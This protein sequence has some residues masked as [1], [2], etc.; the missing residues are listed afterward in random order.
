MLGNK[1]PYLH[2]KVN[3]RHIAWLADTGAMVSIASADQFPPHERHGLVRVPL[4]PGLKVQGATGH[5]FSLAGMFRLQLETNVGTFPHNVLLVEGLHTGKFI[6]GVDFLHKYGA[7]IDCADHKITFPYNSMAKIDEVAKGCVTRTD[8]QAQQGDIT[9]QLCQEVHLQ[10]GGEKQIWARAT[11]GNRSDVHPN[12]PFI[13]SGEFTVDALV[14]ADNDSK[15]PVILHNRS[16]HPITL[17]RGTTVATGDEVEDIMQVDEVL[18]GKGQENPRPTPLSPEKWAYLRRVIKHG[19]HGRT[20]Q[21]FW[22]LVKEHHEAFSANAFDL[23]RTNAI[24][25]KILMRNKE[26]V[27][28]KQF[29]LNWSSMKTIDDHVDEL[30]KKDCIEPSLSRF[31][32]PIFVVPKKDHSGEKHFRVVQDLREVN[33]NSLDDKYVGRD[34]GDCLGAIGRAKSTIFSKLD[35]TSGFWQM[36]LHPDSREMTAFTIPGR[37][38]FHWTVTTMG[39]KGSPASFA[40]LMD[41]VMANVKGVICYQ[42]DCLVHGQ[43]AQQHMAALRNAFIRLKKFSLKLNA[44]KC[45]FA[46]EKV[47]Y[48]G[49]TLTKDGI[50]PGIDKLKAVREF[51]AP[52]NVKAVRSF[53]GLTNYFRHMVPDYAFLSTHLSHLLTKEANWTGGPL[54]PRATHAFNELRKRLCEAP[55]LAFPRTDRPFSV[56]VDAATGDQNN[57]GGIGAVLTQRDA[58][59]VEHVIAYG[60]RAL[61]KHEKN[62]S[63]YLLEALAA[64]YF[65]DHW[66]VFLK[67]V[68]FT[69]FT[70]HKPLEAL[71]HLHK[72]TLNRLQQQQSEF[73]FT[74]RHRPGKTNTVADALSRYPVRSSKQ[75]VATIQALG[76]TTN[77]IRKLQSE[78]TFCRD[79]H[80]FRQD[81]T[82]PANSKDRSF[83]DR[84]NPQISQESDGLLYYNVL[85]AAG[86]DSK[87]MVLPRVLV[88]PIYQFAHCSTLAGHGGQQRTLDRIQTRYW[89]PGMR[90]EVK[91][92]VNNCLTCRKSK[93]PRNFKRDH[94]PVQALPIPDRPGRRLH[95]DLF[96]PVRTSSKGKKYILTCSDAFSK[97]CEA[98]AIPDKEAETVAKAIYKGFLCRHGLYEQIV[99]DRGTDFNS[100][101]GAAFY[102]MLGIKHTKTASFHPASNAQAEVFNKQ[103][104][105]YYKAMLEDTTTLEWE[106]LLP[107]L[108]MAFNSSVHSTTGMSPF[109]CMFL[110]DPNLPGFDQQRPTKIYAENW[111]AEA[112]LTRRKCE[113]IAKEN[114][115]LAEH[116]RQRN[117]NR[118]AVAPSNYQV[119]DKVLLYYPLSHFQNAAGNRKFDQQWTDGYVITGIVG[120]ET[121]YCSSSD[122]A[123]RPTVVHADRLQPA[124]TSDIQTSGMKPQ[125]RPGGQ[126]Q[127]PQQGRPLQHQRRRPRR[128]LQPPAQQ[129]PAPP[130]PS[131]QQ[132]QKQTS[133]NDKKTAAS[134]KKKVTAAADAP[135]SGPATRSRA[136]QGYERGE[137]TNQGSVSQV[138]ANKAVDYAKTY[139]DVVAGKPVKPA[140]RSKKIVQTA[141]WL[142]LFPPSP[143]RPARHA[144][145]QQPGPPDDDP[146]DPEDPEGEPAA[147][148][149]EEEQPAANPDEEEQQGPLDQQR[150]E[151]A[152]LR[153]D[154]LLVQPQ[155]EQEPARADPHRHPEQPGQEEQ[156]PE[157]PEGGTARHPLV[158]PAPQQPAAGTDHDDP[159]DLGPSTGSESFHSLDSP[160]DPDSTT[161]EDDDGGDNQRDFTGYSQEELDSAERSRDQ[162]RAEGAL[163]PASRA[164]NTSPTPPPSFSVLPPGTA[165][166]PAGAATRTARKPA[167]P[168]NTP[169]PPSRT[170]SPPPRRPRTPPPAARRA[171]RP[172]T[173]PPPRT[174]SPAAGRANAPRPPPPAAGEAPAAW[175]Q[176]PPG[177]PP[178]PGVAAGR[179]RM[180]QMWHDFTQAANAADRQL[181]GLPPQP[182]PDTRALRSRGPAEDHPWVASTPKKPR[183]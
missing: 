172:A 4:D 45:D 166:P 115:M 86:E 1:R 162:Q 53:L 125:P 46:A 97:Y 170:P 158:Q 177:H 173:P 121:Y 57:P 48:L 129:T 156:E 153:R 102:K 180:R 87:V 95:V 41:T 2:T 16:A 111:A 174:P 157:E 56:T 135:Y 54:P 90:E 71:S 117:N 82:L 147:D 74:I 161:H 19:F 43:D 23:G 167:A 65:I 7:I 89:W 47:P 182:P 137:A 25:H 12:T 60:S 39:L 91:E 132:R 127:Q 154:A 29:P 130:P 98:F 21:Q 155:E 52:T 131:E 70:D 163:D 126:E 116:N 63:A 145:Q 171:T 35:L 146:D 32:S 85:D 81:G 120:P 26:P 40:R 134:K 103:I 118:H 5:N 138:M 144:A 72:K 139:A 152:L 34:I 79:V 17:P 24:Q 93:D 10:P 30:L 64:T 124:P 13:Y 84:V 6:L 136:A 94:A 99:S 58:K 69:L 68:H 28:V 88:D 92:R 108:C 151:R 3:G 51:P 76:L 140:P 141:P 18:L 59:G 55:V 83:L 113:Q 42:D 15:V 142:D 169:E 149:A 123:K 110:R 176:D 75:E 104:T 37:G 100:R 44:E 160:I 122:K 165:P 62:Y 31:N 107:D 66:S 133:T 77:Q 27:H 112:F 109:A 106:D 159:F 67:G 22:D 105:R 183:K 11:N 80:H 128:R 150:L 50:L 36:S 38:R 20:E 14:L 96:G 148:A 78:D 119:G 9:V 61:S 73:D 178:H 181:L 168:P 164:A 33:R 114:A 143:P 49:F 175:G 8:P 179:S 101:V